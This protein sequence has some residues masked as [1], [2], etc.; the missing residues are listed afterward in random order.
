M[1]R[2]A[3]MFELAGISFSGCRAL[4]LDGDQF[5]DSEKGSIN[6][7]MDGTPHPL[8]IDTLHKGTQFGCVIGTEDGAAPIAKVHQTINAIK[9]AKGQGFFMFNYVDE[10]YTLQLKV[11]RDWT[12][13]WYQYGRFS[14][15][16]LPNVTFRLVV[17]E[18]VVATL[19]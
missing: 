11:I 9:A 17:R 2:Y 4:L 15:G 16:Y 1:A 8:T 18:A 14:E 13:R 3:T 6:W 19:S 10:Q 12:Q 5:A 7:A